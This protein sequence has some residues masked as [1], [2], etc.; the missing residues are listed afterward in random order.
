LERLPELL[1]FERLPELFVLERLLELLVFERLPE[2]FVF[3]RLVVLRFVPL[4]F[5]PLRFVVLRLVVLRLAVV[6]VFRRELPPDEELF[7]FELPLRFA[8]ERF[9]A[10]LTSFVC[11]RVIALTVARRR[12]AE[13]AQ[14]V[15]RRR[16]K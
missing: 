15:F 5:V 16:S 9:L 12:L 14:R 3:E 2:L 13:N 11:S 4:R 7:L 6:F 1:V 10:T 8:C